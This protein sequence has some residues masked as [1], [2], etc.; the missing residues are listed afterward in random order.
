[1]FAI[2][3]LVLSGFFAGVSPASATTGTFTATQTVAN[4]PASTI[5][6]VTFAGGSNAVNGVVPAVTF[7]GGANAVT[8]SIP[9]ITFAGGV[10]GVAATASTTIPAGL[11]AN[12]TDHSI[13][14]DGV[15]INLGTAAQSAVQVASTIAGTNFSTGT[16]FLADGAY[17][18]SNVGATVTFTR[19]AT[20][21]A[22]NN[23]L[24]IA[25][26]DFTSV[27]AAAASA[28]V[29]VPAGLAANA[30]DEIIMIDGVSIDLGTAAQTA[31]QVASTIAGSDF[32][33]GTSYMADGAYT[34]SNVGGT[35]AT[36]TFTRT[37]TGTAGNVNL[38]VADADYTTTNG[39]AATA[40]TTIP[41]ALP[42]NAADHSIMIDGVTIDL[43]TGIRSAASIGGLIASTDFSSGTSFQ[44]DGSYTVTNNNAVVTFTR[45]NTGTAGNNGLTI[46]DADFTGG[47]R[48]AR[49]VT[50]N[51]V[52]ANGVNLTIGTCV[53]SFN[54]I[55]TAD[56]D[57][58]NN[59]AG[60]RTSVDNTAALVA[61]RLR[62][63]I[64]VSDVGHGALTVAGSGTTASFTTTGPET[65]ATVITASLS[66]GA[67]IILTTV[68]TTGVVFSTATIPAL[69]FTG[70]VTLVT[71]SLVPVVTFG[72]GVDI[73][74]SSIPSITFAGGVNGVAATASTTIPAGLAANATDHS[75]TIDGVV[76]NLGTAAQSAVQVASTIAGT[77]FSTGTSY[78]A[79]GAYTVSNVGGTSA[80]VTFTRTATGTAGNNGLTIADT[81]YTTVNAVTASVTVTITD[82]LA[83]NANDHSITIDG[84]TIDLGTSALTANQ[85]AAAIAA[86]PFTGKDYTVTNPSGANLTFTKNLGGT[87]GN[88]SLTLQD[89]LYT[90]I[91]A[92]SA[93]VT[94][95]IP[96]GLVANATDHVVIIDGV[97][98]DLGTSA[99]TANQVAAAIAANPFTGKDYTVTNPSGANLT[100]TKN[101]GGTAGN[102][103]LTIQDAS[104][105]AVA[106]VATFTPAS[107]TATETYRAT[108]NG[109]NYDY[110][111][112]GGD[113]VATVVA[114]LAP[115]MDANPAVDCSQDTTK[116]TCAA[117]VAGTAFTFSATVISGA[118]LSSVHIGSNNANPA[119]AK[120]GDM[121][122]L[123]FSSSVSIQSV[124][125]TI[126]G[127]PVTASGSGAGPYT[128]TYMMAT[129][130]TEGAVAFT[131][132]FTDMASNPG[133]TVTGTT[134][135]SSI[136][137]DKTPPATPVITSIA[138]DNFINNSEKTAIVVLGTAEANSSVSVSLA[139]GATVNSI[140]TADG[141]GNF[142]ATIDGTT[143]TDGTI[144]PSVVVMDAAGNASAA[145]MTPTAVKDVVAPTASIS[146]SIP[147]AVRSGDSLTIT[148]T[149]SEPILDSPVVKLAIS[150]SNTLAAAD[151]TKTDGTHYT[152]VFTVGSGDGAASVA[153]SVGTDAAGN[154]VASTPTN[155]AAFTVN[156]TTPIVPN[157]VT[158]SDSTTLDLSSG[159]APQTSADVNVEGV[160]TVSMVKSVLLR[161]AT[162]G[163]PVVIS[164][165]DLAGVNVSIPDGTT[166]TGPNGWDG[167]ILPPKTNT[168]SS[169]T[170][171]SGFQ[172]GNN[173][174]EVGSLGN[175]LVLDSPVTITVSNAT[176]PIGYR[177]ANTTMWVA[178]PMCT[179][180]YASPVPVASPNA[181]WI[182]NG[183]DTKIVTFHFSTFAG[184]IAV[185]TGGGGGGGGGG[186]SGNGILPP[187]ASSTSSS[188]PGLPSTGNAVT[189]PAPAGAHPNGTLIYDGQTFYLINN[190]Q[191]I[192]FRDPNEFASYGYKFS[193]GVPANA[194][195]KALPTAPDIARAMAGTLVIDARD[196]ITVYMIG[197]GS[198]ARGFT[199]ADVFMALGYSF[200]GLPRI[201]L[202]DYPVGPVIGSTTDAHPDGSLVLDGNTIWWLQGGQKQGFESMAVFNT[203]GFS[204]S[205]VVP[206]NDSDRAIPEGPIVK[207]R[208]GTLIND[209]VSYYIISDGKKLQFSSAADLSNRGYKTSNAVMTSLINYEA[210]GMVQ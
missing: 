117:S 156:N 161:G 39:V 188:V 52:P 78:T 68:N 151:M 27:N 142:T 87:A 162:L 182:T 56:A 21:T 201:N 103:A 105:G 210:G 196:N 102:V 1:M 90:K 95:T 203:Y 119:Q 120:V 134:D 26:T 101:L 9:S 144:T 97:T 28:T 187:V 178:L 86:N 193:Q 123:T 59:N 29:I 24:T 84:V 93:T 173:I 181:C 57:C 172:I 204:L 165:S 4:V 23:G 114:A 65:S 199:S 113:N 74:T 62:T 131:I 145:A 135:A 126:A 179:G 16:S 190:A 127:H 14:I 200:G 6:S 195:D 77:N 112:A 185:S 152:Y 18:V 89:P 37:A 70:G 191:K 58:G 73:V 147:Y 183:T 155:N 32:S 122:T 208:D 125:V 15:V 137:F 25:D 186:G 8:S 154:I 94:V 88:V 61:A 168:D 79:D 64:N 30:T 44:A 175:V 55:A 72:G 35:S 194:I 209:G 198:T 66:A 20:G 141:L 184:L 3:A 71:S 205:R 133:S 98:I 36:V 96:A 76:I 48:A 2:A 47:V 153:L 124:V 63:L 7:A 148:A 160:A 115:L 121:V 130:D 111:A 180:T 129:G 128:A 67:S 10:N 60:I 11:A 19:T 42:A 54:T 157:S 202:A 53:I 12:A 163:D 80:T 51:S 41:A 92:V 40:S 34:V 159:L 38:L 167:N 75:I 192:G 176:A 50:V 170:P 136:N 118:T 100:F 174:I 207:F 189:T 104:Y 139:G 110:L 91:N 83:G 13:T 146:Y 206:A 5:P 171:P 69:T 169:G 143:L 31:V 82:S 45:D 22:G 197:T 49:T 164:N 99:L 149:F 81:D 138:G 43:G 116:I 109:I 33:T 106:Q 107:V 158:L 85:V 140:V 150:G 132:D 108:I 46:A 177:A 17:T 166:I